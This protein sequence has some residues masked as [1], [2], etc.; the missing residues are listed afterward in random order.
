VAKINGTKRADK[1]NGTSENDVINLFDGNDVSHGKKGNDTIKGG[2]G[3]DRLFGDDGDDTLYGGAGADVLTGGAGFDTLLGGGGADSFVYASFKDSG[4]AGGPLDIIYDFSRVEHD[5]IDV[6]AIDA[7]PDLRGN[8]SFTFLGTSGFTGVGAE[9]NFFV[10]DATTTLTIVRF[11]L[12][13]DKQTDFAIALEGDL[14]LTQ[15][16]FVL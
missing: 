8:Q 14:P 16:D 1:L 6:S 3:S 4:F 12:D 5:R 10:V 15:A 11:D 13:G 7:N 9:A 2:A